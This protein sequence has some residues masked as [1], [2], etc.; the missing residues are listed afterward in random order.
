MCTCKVCGSLCEIEYLDIIDGV[1][2]ARGYC[3]SCNTLHST[4]WALK[5]S[6]VEA[7]LVH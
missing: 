6:K 5:S 4:E 3:I 1:L 7:S 2:T